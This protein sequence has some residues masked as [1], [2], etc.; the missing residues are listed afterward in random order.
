MTKTERDRSPLP[1]VVERA[2]KDATSNP[3]VL[4]EIRVA[5]RSLVRESIRAALRMSDAFFSDGE[6][7]SPAYIIGRIMAEP[8]E[9]EDGVLT[10]SP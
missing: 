8:P 4:G 3:A 6:H 7:P 5:V 1:V 2:L 10:V 9:G